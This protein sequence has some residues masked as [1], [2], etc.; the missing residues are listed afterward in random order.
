MQTYHREDA[1]DQVRSQKKTWRCLMLLKFRLHLTMLGFPI[2]HDP[3]YND[4]DARP[5]MTLGDW[6]HHPEVVEALDRME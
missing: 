1:S 4:R 2:V 5:R 6:E 3:L